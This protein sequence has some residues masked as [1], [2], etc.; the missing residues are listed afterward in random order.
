MTPLIERCS[1]RQL[2][3]LG[4]PPPGHDYWDEETLRGAA[5][6]YPGLDLS[7][8]RAAIKQPS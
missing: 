7:L 1:Q 3:V 2:E 5:E 4:F 8:W 6:R